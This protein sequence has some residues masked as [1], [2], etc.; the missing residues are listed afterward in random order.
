MYRIPAICD[1]VS[2]DGC[3]SPAVDAPHPL[4]DEELV[5]RHRA[6]SDRVNGPHFATL[7]ERHHR[8]VV[9]WACRMTGNLEFGKD[10]AQEVFLKAYTRLDAFRGESRFSTWLYSITRNCYRDWLKARSA[11][12]IEVGGDALLTAPPSVAH[13]DGPLALEAEARRAL[14]WRLIRDARLT[15][16][17][18]RVM[19]LHYGA[20]MP[21]DALSASLSLDNASGARA[22][23]VSAKRKLRAA[24]AR[25]R[26]REERVVER[27][28]TV[29]AGPLFGR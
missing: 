11:R 7:F 28:Q 24:V 19:T 10:L 2:F 26:R 20:D 12:V 25:W 6:A 1:V 23:I 15:S 22:F 17:E 3:P 18:R 9:A 21:L 4:S 16:I 5:R 14:T 13:N 8:P 29:D 27:G